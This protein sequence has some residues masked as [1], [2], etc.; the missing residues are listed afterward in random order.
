MK[1]AEVASISS[2]LVSVKRYQ[3]ENKILESWP[4]LRSIHNGS[5]ETGGIS[6]ALPERIAER[7]TIRPGDLLIT[8]KFN[9]RCPLYRVSEF[10]QSGILASQMVLLARSFRQHAINRNALCLFGQH[11]GAKAFKRHRAGHTVQP[12]LQ[13]PPEKLDYG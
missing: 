11:R 4:I 2:G 12:S 8:T 6:L 7:I 13:K 10:D 9:G 3:P 5:I 1:L